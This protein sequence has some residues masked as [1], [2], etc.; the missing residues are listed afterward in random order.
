MCAQ[1]ICVT[2]WNEFIHEKTS[3][4]VGRIYPGGIH[5]AIA[6]ALAEDLGSAVQVRTATLEEP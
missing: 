5:A 3:P 2:V 1:P 4:A 6:E